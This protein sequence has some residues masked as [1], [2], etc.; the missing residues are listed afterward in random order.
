V[1]RVLTGAL[2]G[3]LLA[4]LRDAATP[5][6]AF[7]RAADA[8]STLVLSASL[9]DLEAVP[10]TVTTPVGEA[11]V[12]RLGRRV[13]VVPILRAGLALLEPALRLLP[14]GTRVGFLGLS[15]DEASLQAT[16]YVEHL[17]ADLARDEV[18][19]LDV[20]I[21]TGGSAVAALDAVRAAGVERVHL[22][23]LIAA[24]EGVARLAA[25]HPE[26]RITVAAVDERLDARGFIVPG[27]GDAGDRLYG[28]GA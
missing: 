15:R 26:V 27:L 16:S 1:V 28:A 24:P 2:P 23:G 20:M 9:A 25:R 5:P 13:T 22:A 17:P 3:E 7:R 11:P 14:E 6:A 19:V 8:L 18:V 4:R 21:A 12:M 10:G